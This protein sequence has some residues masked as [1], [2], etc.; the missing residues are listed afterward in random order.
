MFQKSSILL[1]LHKLSSYNHM[2][3]KATKYKELL[4]KE[5]F[6]KEVS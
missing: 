6:V 1:Y 5:N 4:R 3:T 2:L